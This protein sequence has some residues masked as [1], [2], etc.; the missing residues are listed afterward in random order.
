MSGLDSCGSGISLPLSFLKIGFA[1]WDYRV[2]SISKLLCRM[3]FTSQHTTSLSFGSTDAINR[4]HKIART[5]IRFHVHNVAPDDD[6]TNS[7]IGGS[8]FKS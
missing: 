7:A 1:P 2:S 6:H 8:F 3:G 4:K 5:E